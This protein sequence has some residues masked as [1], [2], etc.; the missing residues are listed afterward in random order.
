M[1]EHEEVLKK[2]QS[3]K[4][5][6][7]QIEILPGVITP[8]INN[9]AEALSLL[10]L[11]E[12]CEGKRVLDLGTRDGFFAFEMERRGAEVV[13]ID[14]MP[15]E[16]TGFKVASE[17]LD[18]HVAFQQD[19]IYNVSRE[20]YGEFDIILFLGLFYHLPNPLQA[21]TILRS[22]CKEELYLETYVIDNA[23][24]LPNGEKQPLVQLAK[25]LEDIPLM[26]F[27][28]RNALNNDPSN[29]WGPNMKC[30]EQMLEECNFAVVKRVL[31]GERGIFKC[32][33]RNDPHLRH[34]LDIARGAIL[35]K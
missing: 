27:Y 6:Y 32:A 17:L 7:H 30:V 10:D 23:L 14:Y 20:K 1:E 3:V 5:W 33:I 28:H 9:S 12:R 25:I 22:L 2:I 26:Q 16:R 35:P 31:H 15:A 13:A 8:G 29:F 4:H 18:S 34:Q 11:P 24:L 21:L 19:N